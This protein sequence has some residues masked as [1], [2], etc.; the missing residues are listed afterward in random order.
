M[1]EVDGSIFHTGGSVRCVLVDHGAAEDQGNE[2]D[3]GE[4][5]AGLTTSSHLLYRI[6][7]ELTILYYFR[8]TLLEIIFHDVRARC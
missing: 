3:S 7:S 4:S 5:P 8:Q 2:E 6:H 1:D